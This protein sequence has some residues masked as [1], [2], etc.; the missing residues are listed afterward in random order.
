MNATLLKFEIVRRVWGP[1]NHEMKR[2]K[3]KIMKKKQ[4]YESDSAFGKHNRRER[5]QRMA[6][7]VREKITGEK[8]NTY[9]LILQ[10]EKKK[11][12][13]NLY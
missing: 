10:K 13:I 1:L 11:K 9:V 4:V 12:Y 3:K 2:R 8:S 6:K 7:R 5:E